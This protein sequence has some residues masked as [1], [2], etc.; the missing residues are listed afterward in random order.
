MKFIIWTPTYRENSGGIIVLHKLASLLCEL[1]YS[2]KIW[3]HTKPALIELKSFQ[4]WFRLA[5]WIK[6][7]AGNIFKRRDIRSPYKLEL[8]SSFDIKD[9]IVIYPEI[10]AGN[11]LGAGRVIRWLL[12]SPGVINATK[13]F[14]QSDLFFYYNKHFNDWKLNPHEERH[15]KVFELMSSVYQNVNY[16]ERIGQCYMVRKG[17]NRKLNYHDC[18]AEKVD[19]LSHKELA[20]FFNSTKY[21]IC[22]DLY[23]M[24]CRYAVMCGCIPIVVPQEGLSKY[25]WRP[26]VDLTYGVAYGWEDLKWALDTRKKLLD[27][28]I[29]MDSA[30]VESVKNFLVITREHYP[31]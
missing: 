27:S 31:N 22:Y 5:K 3:P 2:A 11:P 7:T 24:Y 30:G 25:D 13:E 10:V 21:F 26:E 20:I 16:G 15:L 29:T 18:D 1:G 23:T 4:G 9:S 6:F 12:N 8:A 19:G 28:L 14:G 17:K